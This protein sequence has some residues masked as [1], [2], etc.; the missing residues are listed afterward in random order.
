MHLFHIVVHNCIDTRLVTYSVVI[1]LIFC[2]DN[3]THSYWDEFKFMSLLHV[4]PDSEMPLWEFV[5]SVFCGLWCFCNLYFII[6]WEV[7]GFNL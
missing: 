7:I 6:T 1:A 3:L 5:Q 4:L 2:Y